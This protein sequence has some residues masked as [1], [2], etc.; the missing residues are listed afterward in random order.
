MILQEELTSHGMSTSG[1]CGASCYD[2][3]EIHYEKA[4]R[5]HRRPYNF[6][7]AVILQPPWS[8]IGVSQRQQRMKTKMKNGKIQNLENVLVK[9]KS[10]F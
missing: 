5:I 6:H 4:D 1:D 8:C 2:S 10:V 3:F 7:Q 9:F